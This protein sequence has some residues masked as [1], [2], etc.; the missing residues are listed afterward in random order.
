MDQGKVPG[1]YT[2]PATCKHCGP[3]WLWFSGDVLGCPWCWNRIAGRPIP[4][5]YAV[6]CGSCTH[7]ERIDHPHLGHCTAGQPE[8]IAGLW[9]NDRRYCERYLPSRDTEANDPSNEPRIGWCSM[10]STPTHLRENP[11]NDPVGCR[12][13]LEVGL[14]RETRHFP[15][16]NPSTNPTL[17]DEIR[18]NPTANPTGA[19]A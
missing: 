11:M 15:T 12:V 14:L 1:H 9:D 7:F 18:Q 6:C 8:A 3:I 5:P 2:H 10:E 16:P 4:R 17:S 19:T 13:C